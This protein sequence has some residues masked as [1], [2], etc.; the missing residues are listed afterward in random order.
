MKI[1]CTYNGG[2]RYQVSR[3]IATFIF[4]VTMCCCV[5]GASSAEDK[6]IL[7]EPDFRYSYCDY[8]ESGYSL[9]IVGD[10][11][12]LTLSF[13]INGFSGMVLAQKAIFYRGQNMHRYIGK[14]AGPRRPPI[15]E[16]TDFTTV[17]LVGITADIKRAEVFDK[18][19]GPIEVVVSDFSSNGQSFHIPG[20]VNIFC[21]APLP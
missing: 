10:T 18:V 16:T 1:V 9:G 19:N 21:R 4:F 11:W 2:H 15:P 14:S 20:K 6:Q 17:E 8:R 5:S 3:R 12:A 7:L 13:P